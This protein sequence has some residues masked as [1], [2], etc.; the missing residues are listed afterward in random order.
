M[1]DTLKECRTRE[2]VDNFFATVDSQ[3]L[4]N[5]TAFLMEAMNN[6]QFFYSIGN[7]T[8]EQKYEMILTTFLSGK[9]RYADSLR[10]LKNGQ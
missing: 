2:E 5:K 9:W 7:P 8:D 10:S 6:P 3:S 1:P 4:K